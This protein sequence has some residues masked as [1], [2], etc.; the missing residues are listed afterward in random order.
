MAADPDPLADAAGAI[1]GLLRK[2]RVR[3][4][5]SG[6]EEQVLR[7][8]VG[9]IREVAAGKV[10]V[11]ADVTLSESILLVDGMVARYKD[12]ADGQRQILELHVAGDFI[13]LHGFLLKRLEH[14][15]GTLTAVR[16]A[17]VP[18][19]RL[20]RV[21]EEHPHLARM[22]WFS[23]LLDA[24]IHRER[25]LSVGRRTALARIAHLLCELYVRL[26]IVGLARER[27]FQLPLTQADIADVTGLTSVHV[28]RMLK[29]LRD[30]ELLTFRSG[31][32]VIHDWDR[33]QR[34]AE[35]NLN[36]L[37]LER[38]PR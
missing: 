25:I 13:D 19:D 20:R 26:E 27:R 18:H 17:I 3:D 21:T 23:T 35:F 29:K 37:Y 22:L 14:H 9:E 4:L 15:V 28:N 36:Y 32:V 34:T 33:L 12:L 11:R 6:G 2:F 38:R 16:L 8:C 1:E 7:E 10:L 30:D 5:L 24:S 31:E